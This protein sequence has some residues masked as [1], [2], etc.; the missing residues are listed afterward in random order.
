MVNN[1]MHKK[2]P[3]KVCVLNTP[4]LIIVESPS[5]CTKIEKYLG[6]QYKCIASKGHIREIKKIS[7]NYEPKFDIIPEKKSHVAEMRSIISQFAPENIYLASDDDREGEAISWHI[8]Q[9]FNL[10]VENTHRILFHE[11]TENAIQSAVRV[12]VRIRMGVVYAQ[13]A[14]QVLDRLVGFQISPILSNCLFQNGLSAGRCQTPALRLI[15]DKEMQEKPTCMIYKTTA[16]FFSPF[17]SFEFDLNHD[18]QKP[19]ECVEFLQASNFR[20]EFTKESLALEKKMCHTDPP[21]PFNTSRI[22]QSASDTFHYSPKQTMMYCQ[23]LYQGGYITYM[24]TESEKYASSFLTQMKEYIDVIGASY[25]GDFSR[26]ENSTTPHEAIRVTNINTKEVDLDPKIQ[27]LYTWIWKNTL[28]SCMH[29]Y[30]YYKIDLRI[31]APISYY[32]T[33]LEIPY[34]LGWKYVFATEKDHRE[35][36]MQT[37]IYSYLALRITQ[38]ISPHKIKM[39]ISMKENVRHYTESGL[40]KGLEE[41]GIGRPSTY[42]LLVDTIQ[43]RGY[44]KKMDITGEKVK[45]TEYEWSGEIIATDVEKTFGNEKNKLVLQELGKQ[46]IEFLI[47][48]YSTLF[49]YEYTKHLEEKLDEIAGGEKKWHDI[50]KEC[51]E[52]IVKS[53]PLKEYEIDDSHVFM[54]GKNGAVIKHITEDGAEFLSVKKTPIDISK[55]KEKKYDLADLLEV[56]ETLGVHEGSEIH[57][58]SG[59]YGT[60]LEWKDKK[61]SVKAPVTLETA[62]SH[63]EKTNVIR[64]L[65]PDLSILNGKYG[66]Y[67][68]LIRNGKSSCYS[69]KK[70]RGGYKICD[71]DVLIQW[72]KDTYGVFWQDIK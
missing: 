70:F 41:Y 55:L 5:I 57:L 11:I 42:A 13:L 60:Y 50:C 35:A 45:G 43:D 30:D 22:L 21:K 17:P 37:K 66:P 47:P 48:N 53:E 46:T 27:A 4:F 63:L 51:E 54:F 69:L 44:V 72:M 59:P 19:E 1:K 39:R 68:N 56:P 12:P 9:V 52:E 18:F 16:S 8:C 7:K 20:H 33:K 38:K 34:F 61:V 29:T 10:S 64:V 2:I 32:Q 15:Y 40:I 62:I 3:K 71:P 25:L 28:A 58:K 67:L 6:F 14:R 31:S 23:T 49:S 24:R 65:G 26:I 36:D